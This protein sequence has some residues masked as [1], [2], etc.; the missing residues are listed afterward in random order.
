MIRPSNRA[1]IRNISDYSPFG[2]HLFERTIS[3]DGY[4]FGFQGQEMDDEI[5]GEGNSVNYKYRMHHPRLG[6]FFAVDPLAAK[7]TA[8]TPY[9]FCID[10]PILNIDS[11]GREVIVTITQREN[12]KPL[13]EIKVS[14]AIINESKTEFI[15]SQITKRLKTFQSEVN[16]VYNESFKNFEVKV[17][18]DF[19]IVEKREDVTESDHIISIQDT[20]NLRVGGRVNQIGGKIMFLPENSFSSIKD[21][22]RP[23][24]LGHLLGLLH[25]WDNGY[26]SEFKEG[27]YNVMSYDDEKGSTIAANK[28]TIEDHQI[29]QITQLFFAGK[30]NQGSNTSTNPKESSSKNID[31]YKYNPSSVEL[32]CGETECTD[33]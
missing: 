22:P 15:N 25:P 1:S 30:L 18:L 19:R 16:D 20:W 9:A 28:Y 32:N 29:M 3:G 24:E 21:R 11:D 23:H 17:M 7:Y 5:K 13:V 8:W 14:G 12:Q 10:N 27:E 2:V 33:E 26:E 4:R 31:E 6:R